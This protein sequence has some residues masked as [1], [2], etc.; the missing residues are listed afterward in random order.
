MPIEEQL[1][2]S[3]KLKPYYDKVVWLYACRT[4]KK[5]T[6]K[7][8]EALRTHDRFGISSWPQQFVFD[9]RD[10]GVLTNM[11]RKLEPFMASLDKVLKGWDAPAG[12][13][14]LHI[15]LGTARAAY[16]RGDR[17]KAIAAIEPLA[18][19]TDKF[20]GWLEARELLRT[21]KPGKDRR[22]PAERLSDP[23]PRERAIALEEL[24]LKP[25]KAVS[26]EQVTTLLTSEQEDIVVRIR[27]L[28][29]LASASPKSVTGHAAKLLRLNNDPF[30]YEVL[31]VIQKHPDPKLEAALISLF[32]G[33]GT[34]DYPS[35]NPNVVRIRAAQCLAVCGGAL[36]IDALA[37]PA[38]EC[39]PRNGLTRIVFQSLAAIG[40]RVG[41]ADRKKITNI[42]IDSLPKPCDVSDQ[43]PRVGERTL[44]RYL[45]LIQELLKAIESVSGNRQ[46][47]AAP[48]A[49]T[50]KERAELYKQLRRIVR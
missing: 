19:R 13:P 14:L 22:K 39:D 30:R 17:R 8:R 27:A 3:K 44:R 41:K 5:E 7:D 11:P 47:P 42:L 36:S 38:R 20:E 48:T 31:A 2:P 4:F 37:K 43:E 25:N 6:L 46:L 1:L 23:D 16:K 40:S 34:K 26:K 29:Y 49:W 12:S 35:R 24:T 9:P 45:N 21:W 28:R 18:K 32:N 15:A 50:S 33:A 10:D